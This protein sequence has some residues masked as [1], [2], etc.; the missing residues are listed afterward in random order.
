MDPIANLLTSIRNAYMSRNDRTEAPH[1]KT[2]EEILRVLK[3]TGFISDFKTTTKNNHKVLEITLSYIPS[4]DP[5]LTS[6]KRVSRPSVRIYADKN[7]LP[8]VLS[9]KGIAI[10][11][12]SKGI[13]TESQARSSKL[14]GEII[15]TVS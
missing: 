5:I 6:I 15:C 12:T 1:S 10:I 8:F 9:G 4:G 2:K 11:S 14:G 7:S 13:M 3:E